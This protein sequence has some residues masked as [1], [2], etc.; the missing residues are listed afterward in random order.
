M[1]VRTNA[2]S[3][4]TKYDHTA[5]SVERYGSEW[6][7]H[8]AWIHSNNRCHHLGYYRQGDITS[9]TTVEE[10]GVLAHRRSGQQGVRLKIESKVIFTDK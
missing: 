3:D 10:R 1:P 7:V 9:V 4:L 8:D 6:S 2:M 5:D